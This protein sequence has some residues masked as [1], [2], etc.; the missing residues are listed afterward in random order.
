MFCSKCGKQLPDD[1][2]TCDGC[3]ASLK[4][5]DIIALV[6]SKSTLLNRWIDLGIEFLKK[7][8]FV[9]CPPGMHH[10]APPTLL[11]CQYKYYALHIRIFVKGQ[12][13]KRNRIALPQE[14]RRFASTPDATLRR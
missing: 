13:Y 14:E 7:I 10:P 4:S 3:G 9:L 6:D 11:K 2:V 5:T 8:P 12:R 1:A